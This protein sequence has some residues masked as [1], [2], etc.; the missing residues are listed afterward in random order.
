MANLAGERKRIVE[1]ALWPVL[2]ADGAQLVYLSTDPVTLGNDLYRSGPD[3]ANPAPIL[4][5]GAY[6]PV[7]AHLFTLDGSQLIFSMVNAQPAPAL[8]WLDRL[9]G[10]EA[11]SAHSVPSDWYRV[12]SSGGTPQRLT[13]LNDVNLNGDL[14][15]DGRQ[16]AFIG[17]SGLYIMNVDGSGLV[18]LAQGAW[19]GTVS[20]VP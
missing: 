4:P 12:A 1:R 17:A 16:M 20:W 9:L 7:D 11:A 8:S 19:V 6:P 3:G 13:E 2:S 15:P 5:P 14:S 18:Q 10:V